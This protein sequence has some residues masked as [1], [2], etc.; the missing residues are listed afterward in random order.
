[1]FSGV[2]SPQRLG[3]K[4]KEIC[5]RVWGRKSHSGVHRWS[6]GR[7][8]GDEVP[9][10]SEAISLNFMIILTYFD[11]EKCKFEVS[12]TTVKTCK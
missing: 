8:L 4:W 12:Y 7:G 6:P 3:A 1:M 10:S 2:A 11:H 5:Q 9:R